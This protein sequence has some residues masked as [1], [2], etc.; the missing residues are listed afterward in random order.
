VRKSTILA[1]FGAL[2]FGFDDL[3]LLWLLFN[4]R[5]LLWANFVYILLSV[6]CLLW[7]TFGIQMNNEQIL[8]L[9]LVGILKCVTIREFPKFI[10]F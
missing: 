9:K 2:K 1:T 4:Y 7:L 8:S 3:L 6:S 5:W 10:T